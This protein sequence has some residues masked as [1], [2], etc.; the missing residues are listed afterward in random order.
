MRS[1]VVS[2]FG[3]DY[4]TRLATR[5]V[6]ITIRFITT[7]LCE[8]WSKKNGMAGT[9]QPQRQDRE[10]ITRPSMKIPMMQK[11]SRFALSFYFT[12]F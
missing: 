9:D 8:K 4:F 12:L 11:V 3:Y 1:K 6:S 2:K 10:D 7:M 5:P